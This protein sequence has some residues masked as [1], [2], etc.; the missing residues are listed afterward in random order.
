MKDK[1]PSQCDD[2][3]CPCKYESEYFSQEDK[4][5]ECKYHE[6]NE[7]CINSLK[8]VNAELVEC[9]KRSRKALCEMGADKQSVS[10]IDQAIAKAGII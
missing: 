6:T 4:K 7:E 1:W 8:I 10:Y 2:P 5:V 3:Q 9:L